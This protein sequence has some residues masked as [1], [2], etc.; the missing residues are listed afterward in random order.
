MEK[1]RFLR[2]DL[3][4]RADLVFG[5]SSQEHLTARTQNFSRDGI[6]FEAEADSIPD[7]ETVHMDIAPAWDTSK[8]VSLDGHVAW[9]RMEGN[10]CHFGILIQGMDAAEKSDLLD[11]S[12]SFWQTVLHA[13]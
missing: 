10:R 7:D 12:Y 11:Q 5:N 13:R 8:K 2:F 3:P 9:R 4:G 6:S 1:R